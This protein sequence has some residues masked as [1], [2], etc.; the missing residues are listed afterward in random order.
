M[1]FINGVYKS[2][3]WQDNK[4]PAINASNM[5]DISTAI[6]QKNN[7]ATLYIEFDKDITYTDLIFSPLKITISYNPIQSQAITKTYNMF[8][9]P[10][11]NDIT[12]NIPYIEDSENMGILIYLEFT[13]NNNKYTINFGPDL[14]GNFEQYLNGE[15]SYG[16]KFVKIKI[17]NALLYRT[18]EIPDKSVNNQ[19]QFLHY[20][21]EKGIADSFYSIGDIVGN[22]FHNL[23]G[24]LNDIPTVHNNCDYIIIGFNHNS[25]FEGYGKTHLM[26]YSTYKNSIRSLK[27]LLDGNDFQYKLRNVIND[28]PDWVKSNIYI[29]LQNLS[30]Y[31]NNPT[32]T[33]NNNISNVIKYS[34]DEF[35]NEY[36][37]NQKFFIPSFY[38]IFGSTTNNNISVFNN[39]SN[40]QKQYDFFSKFNIRNS[41]GNDNSPTQYYLRSL[42]K[43][44]VGNNNCIKINESGLPVSSD[45]TEV[46]GVT[47]CFC[48]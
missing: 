40:H 11:F 39:E 16:N 14:N 45:G 36:Y 30:I 10:G 21:S 8:V 12:L 48:V 37:T 35:G 43:N 18:F 19:L 24:E 4:S 47:Y 3:N 6:T 7:G 38:E 31:I 34:C 20:L 17:D 27:R 28:S 42:I 29:S 13:Y 44:P 23:Y 32:I 5:N 26:L 25:E 41:V 22:G 2:P 15:I 46:I 9:Q 33:Y 1:P